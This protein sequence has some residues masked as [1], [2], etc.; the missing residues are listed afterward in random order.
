MVAWW[1]PRQRRRQ[2]SQNGTRMTDGQAVFITAQVDKGY[3]WDHIAGLMP[4]VADWFDGVISGDSLR[5]RYNRAVARIA[6][7]DTDDETVERS[8]PTSTVKDIK[9]LDDLIARFKVDTDKWDASAVNLKA[10]AWD[11]PGGKVGES[12]KLSA[13]FKRIKFTVDDAHEIWKQYMADAE[14]HAPPAHEGG[15][16]PKASHGSR[17]GILSVC[18]PHFGMLAHRAEVGDNY[19]LDI[20]RSDY[21]KVSRGLL[22]SMAEQG[23]IDKVC[24]IV[25]ND[26]FHANS[27]DNKVAVTR[28][29]TPQDV[30]SRFHRV[31]TEVRRAVV[32]VIDYANS[33][34]DVDVVMVPGNHDHDEVYRLGEVLDAWYRKDTGVT[35]TNTANKRV[36][37]GF[38]ANSFMF[39]HGEEYR[40]KRENLAMILLS[41]MPNALL[42]ASAKGLRE[43]LTGHN[44]AAMVGGYY[45]TA[46]LSESR[47]VRVRSLPGLTASD[48]WHHDEGYKHHRAGTLLIYDREGGLHCYFERRP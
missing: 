41:E 21:V 19:D 5:K 14:G 17:V 15:R 36:F 44:H 18:D 42:T 31:F 40:R 30:D 22:H 39:T 1:H 7:H 37:Y 43:V 34:V 46:E 35:V 38:G 3:R 32:Q 4:D 27:M 29:G 9:N 11:M 48:A 25:G 12:V 13:Q 23:A 26:L 8:A 6:G 28:K 10:S 16:G 47:G 45:P 2:M 33:L 20:A 24:I